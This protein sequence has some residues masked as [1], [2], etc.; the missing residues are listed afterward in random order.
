MEFVKSQFDRIQQ[1]LNGLSASQKM[2]TAALVTIMVMTLAMWGR[3]AG[4]AE[5]VPVLDQS[6]AADELSRVVGELKSKG[7]SHK[8]DGARILVPE[9]KRL[10]ALAYLGYGQMLP[11]D[12]ANAFDEVTKSLN[13][14]EAASIS[15]AKL[16]RAKEK[17]LGDIIGAFPGV[18]GAQ[19][20]ISTDA[21]RQIGANVEP[22]ATISIQMRDTRAGGEGVQQLVN[23][24]ADTVAGAHAG[25]ATKRIKVSVNGKP[26]KIQGADDDAGLDEQQQLATMQQN[27]THFEDKIRKHFDYIPNLMVTVAVKLQPNRTEKVSRIFDP[28]GVISKPTQEMEESTESSPT[29]PPAGEPGVGSNTPLEVNAGQGGG[30]GGVATTHNSSK[31]TIENRYSESNIRELTPAGAATPLSASVRVPRS[32]FVSVLKGQKPDA[33]EPDP[34]AVEDLIL[35]EMPKIK[36]GVLKSVA[37]TSVDAISVD[38][39]LDLGNGG[40]QFVGA[41]ETATASSVSFLVGGHAKELALGALAAVSLFMVSMMVRKSAPVPVMIA[42]APVMTG[43]IQLDSGEIVAGEVGGGDPLLDGMELSDEAV[44]TQQMLNQVGTLVTE[45]PDAAAALVKRWMNK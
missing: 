30:G 34:K 20:L 38:T 24:A 25:L 18:K 12:F 31:T 40:P 35:A 2:L 33:K 41:P 27:E 6:F 3:Y 17:T 7:I 32:Y 44:R 1:Q 21:R 15:A 23:A 13:P 16:N 36:A 45:N 39:Y 14:F 5:F 10:E 4:D 22:S 11:R 8:I 43:P 37:F 42:S 28:A 26:R 19:V 9:D 29:L